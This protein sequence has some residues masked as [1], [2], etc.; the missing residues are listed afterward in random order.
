MIVKFFDCE[1]YSE[2]VNLAILEMK[3]NGEMEELVDKW[4]NDGA[5]SGDDDDDDD[6]VTDEV[7]RFYGLVYPLSFYKDLTF[8]IYN[9]WLIYL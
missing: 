5:C 1:I 7:S 9:M 3:E 6:D 2:R 8:Y 4:W